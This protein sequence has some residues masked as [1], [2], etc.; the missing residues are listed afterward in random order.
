MSKYLLLIL[1][2]ICL[3]TCTNRHVPEIRRDC[4]AYYRYVHKHWKRSPNV[5]SL[6]YLETNR[7]SIDPQRLDL[8]AQEDCVVGLDTTAVRGLFGR[9]SRRVSKMGKD[10][11]VNVY[12]YYYDKTIP[13][14]R[15]NSWIHVIFNDYWLVVQVFVEPGHMTKNW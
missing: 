11:K 8:L 9:P 4:P 10:G 7:S 3:I 2:F 12:A 5:D 1:P 13:G 15:R 6:Y 14:N